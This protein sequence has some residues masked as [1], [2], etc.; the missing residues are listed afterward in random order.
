[1]PNCVFGTVRHQCDRGIACEFRWRSSG[2][3]VGNPA[4]SLAR[5]PKLGR[6]SNRLREWLEGGLKPHSAKGRKTVQHQFCCRIQSSAGFL[7][8]RRYET[9]LRA[10][11]NI[12]SDVSWPAFSDELLKK[13]FRPMGRRGTKYSKRYVT[14]AVLVATIY[15]N[16]SFAHPFHDQV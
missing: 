5:G 2:Y 9:G 7:R 16:A 15:V 4:H 1:M 8:C 14:L 11:L 6:I 3:Y 13:K 12:N 10:M